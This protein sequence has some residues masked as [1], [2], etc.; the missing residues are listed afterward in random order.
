MSINKKYYTYLEPVFADPVIRNY[1]SLVASLLLIAFLIVFA[2]SPTIN[3]ILGLKK[4]IDDQKQTIK[5]L[6]EKISALA[7]A[8]SSYSQAEPYLLYLDVAIPENPKP[9]III[10]DIKQVASAS[11]VSLAAYQIRTIPLSRDLPL[12]ETA[13]G[14]PAVNFALTLTGPQKN[15]RTYLGNLENRLRYIRFEKFII[16]ADGG[17]AEGLAYFFHE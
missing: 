13:L 6:D 4:Q 9:Q 3:V 5:Q 12:T 16:S 17:N 14:I 8:Q 11:A 15:I 2:L 7:A 10:S 1:F